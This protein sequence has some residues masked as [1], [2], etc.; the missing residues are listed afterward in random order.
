MVGSSNTMPSST[1]K[2]LAKEPAEMLRMMTS[3]GTMETFLTRVSR[4]ESCS[5]KCVGTPCFSSSWNIWLLITLLIT[6]L[7]VMVPFFSPLNA[8]ASSLVVND[9][10][11]WVVGSK[12]LLSL[13]FVQLFF[14]FPCPIPPFCICSVNLKLP[15]ERLPVAFA[16]CTPRRQWKRRSALPRRGYGLR[17]LCANLFRPLRSLPLPC[18]A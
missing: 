12:Y 11:I 14:L 16:G 3:S 4:S 10:E 18:R 2:R 5:T 17:E 9:Y 6:P 8:V 15:R 13:A 1:P 7:P